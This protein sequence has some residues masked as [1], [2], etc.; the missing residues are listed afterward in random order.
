MDLVNFQVGAKTISLPILDILLTEQFNNDLTEVPNNNPNFIGVREF[1]GTPVPIFDLGLILNRHSTNSQNKDIIKQLKN[2]K[3]QSKSWLNTLSSEQQGKDV[4][5]EHQHIEFAKWLNDFECD[6]EDLKT[7]L[8]RVKEALNV[9]YEEFSELDDTTWSA[10]KVTSK[11]RLERL[12]DSAIEQV[13]IGYKP[14]IVF[15]T[16]DGREPH[17]GLLVDKVKDS[18]HVEEDDI[19]SLDAVTATGFELEAETSRMLKGLIQLEKR[20]SLIIETKRLFSDELNLGQKT[21]LA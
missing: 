18:I 19:K 20:H 11:T 17:V 5:Q 9:I 4:G 13:E 21:A 6:D 14:I 10:K 3:Q 1:M 16:I 7:L 15:T 8:F 12:F 2:L